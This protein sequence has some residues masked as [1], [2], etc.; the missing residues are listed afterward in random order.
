MSKK[1]ETALSN[2]CQAWVKSIG[3]KSMKIHGSI[4]QESGSPDLLGG[5]KFDG[6]IALFFIELKVGD[7]APTS[8]Q[9]VR[10]EEWAEVGFITGVAYTLE[11]FKRIIYAGKQELMAASTRRFKPYIAFGRQL[12]HGRY[13]DWQNLDVVSGCDG[14]WF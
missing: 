8:I 7:N 14:G 4:F 1:S 2:K 9:C 13:G 12:D 10:L 3:G 11:E 5:I 6:V